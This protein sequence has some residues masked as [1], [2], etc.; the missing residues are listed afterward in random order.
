MKTK[1]SIGEMKKIATKVLDSLGADE[2]AFVPEFDFYWFVDAHTLFDVYVKSPVLTIA[3]IEEDIGELKDVALGK[4]EPIAHDLIALAGV[5]RH[6]AISW[7]K[8]FE[9]K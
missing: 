8:N 7:P 6:M 9:K 2:D 5:F 3:Q 4:S 1:I